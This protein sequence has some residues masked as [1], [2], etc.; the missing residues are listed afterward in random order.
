MGNIPWRTQHE[1][2]SS[3]SSEKINSLITERE[4]ERGRDE[5]E[6]GESEKEICQ[7][8]VLFRRK[9]VGP[10]YVFLLRHS[11]PAGPRLLLYTITEMI[12]EHYN[13]MQLNM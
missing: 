10:D 5:G 2:D 1:G 3:S 7:T 8:C 12:I 13:G 11:S 9:C 4:G 6:D